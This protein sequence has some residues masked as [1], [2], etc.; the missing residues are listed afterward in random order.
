MKMSA[1]WEPYNTSHGQRRVDGSLA[2]AE[3]PSTSTVSFTPYGRQS[4][5]CFAPTPKFRR[6]WT[7]GFVELLNYYFGSRE[8][9]TLFMNS[10]SQDAFIAPN[11]CRLLVGSIP[12]EGVASSSVRF[13]SYIYNA[14]SSYFPYFIFANY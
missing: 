11:T 7:D 1:F 2:D 8:A 14:H 4:T 6:L 13:F 5:F 9:G 12:D 3:I 10:S